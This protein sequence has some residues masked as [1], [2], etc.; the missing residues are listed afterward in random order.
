MWRGRWLKGKC[1]DKNLSAEEA[2]LVLPV[3][4]NLKQVSGIRWA[5]RFDRYNRNFQ[6]PSVAIGRGRPDFLS[7]NPGPVVI[8]NFKQVLNMGRFGRTNGCDS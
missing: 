6:V 4:A 2:L 1:P 3:L 7:E 5:D 8:L